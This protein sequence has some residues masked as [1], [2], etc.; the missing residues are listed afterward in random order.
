M[1]PP[2]EPLIVSQA[3]VEPPKFLLS[4]ASTD[5][6]T[7]DRTH[8]R[9]DLHNESHI[10]HLSLAGDYRSLIMQWMQR[11]AR[12]MMHP[13]S[14]SRL[15]YELGRQVGDFSEY[16]FRGEEPDADRLLSSLGPIDPELYELAVSMCDRAATLR[17]NI[18]NI[19]VHHEWDFRTEISDV[20]D[21]ERQ[22][23]WLTCDPTEPVSFIVA[24]GYLVQGLVY[25]KQLVMTGPGGGK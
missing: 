3:C 21:E 11:V 16:L 1:Q 17:N 20:I 9:A 8:G 10:L 24:P 4:R 13:K 12:K 6:R 14:R 15:E 23:A 7:A 18:A 25:S 22:E 19:G 5:L 2:Y